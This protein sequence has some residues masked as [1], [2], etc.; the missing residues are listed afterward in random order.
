MSK[1]TTWMVSMNRLAQ[2]GET[3]GIMVR[4]M[5]VLQDYALANHAMETWKKEEDPKRKDRKVGAGRYFLRLQMSHLFE[6]FEIIK[7]E[8]EKSDELKAA[9][10]ACDTQTKKSYQ[11]LLEFL[12]GDDYKLLLHIRN[13]IGFHYDRKVVLQSLE[14]IEK[15]QERKRQEKK[16]TSDLAALTLGR[17]ALDWYLRPTEWLANDIIVHWIFK[18]P[19]YE[20][21]ADIQEKTDEIVMRLHNIAAVFADFAGYFIKSHAKST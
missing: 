20:E 1:S 17:E 2:Q 7:K 21:P 4:L 18:I 3:G 15:R 12:K 16:Y 19:E 10:E 8:I 6:A 14:R 9:I 11:A 5:M 13:K